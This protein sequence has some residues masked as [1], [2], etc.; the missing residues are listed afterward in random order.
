MRFLERKMKIK[1]DIIIAYLV[2]QLFLVLTWLV[3]DYIGEELIST[4]A[5]L[6]FAVNSCAAIIYYYLIT[7][8]KIKGE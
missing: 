2:T 7:T 8:K 3:L 1:K 5:F 6:T 4:L